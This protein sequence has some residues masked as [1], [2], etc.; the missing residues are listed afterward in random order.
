LH[1]STKEKWVT[2]VA[3]EYVQSTQA[4]VVKIVSMSRPGNGNLLDAAMYDALARAFDAAASDSAV[5]C[6]LLNSRGST[7]SI[8]HGSTEYVR[9][10]EP[11]VATTSNNADVMDRFHK[12]LL[13]QLRKM[14]MPLAAAVNGAAAGAGVTLALR[15]DVVIAA[16]SAT[17]IEPSH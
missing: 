10:A 5:R 6:V 13:D 2:V 11:H 15:C 4:G 16:R 17:F 14:P 9:S 3:D 8:G 7:F 12:P 1:V